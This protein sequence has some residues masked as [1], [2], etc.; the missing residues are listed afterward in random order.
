M[1]LSG[2]KSRSHRRT[3]HKKAG[4]AGSKRNPFSSKAKASR[5]TRKGLKYYKKAGRTLKFK[6]AKKGGS[7]KH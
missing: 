4:K 7:K 1:K 2:G 5:S 6:K 3:G